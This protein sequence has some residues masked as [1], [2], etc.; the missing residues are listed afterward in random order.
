[1]AATEFGKVYLS[2][3][4]DSDASKTSFRP[5]GYTIAKGNTYLGS[6]V[7]YIKMAEVLDYRFGKG[8]YEADAGDTYTFRYTYGNGDYYEGRVQDDLW[9]TRYYPGKAWTKRNETGRTGAYKITGLSY[10]GV[11]ATEYGK[12]YL[13]SYYDGD[14]SQTLFR[15][16]GYTTFKGDA[17]LG[18]EAGYIIK[19]NTAAY[20]FGKGY[21]EADGS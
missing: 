7:G 8:W 14:A 1:V 2:S 21:Y 11:A 4:Y 5:V 6:E 19:L 18:S 10:K 12:V 16:L 3:Y 15:P 17:Y 20:Y 9:S 13:S